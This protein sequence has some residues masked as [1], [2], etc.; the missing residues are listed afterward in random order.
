LGQYRT[1]LIA[2]QAELNFHIIQTIFGISRTRYLFLGFNRDFIVTTK[3]LGI[4]QLRY[5]TIGYLGMDA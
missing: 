5:K 2:K 4:H 3:F 1:D